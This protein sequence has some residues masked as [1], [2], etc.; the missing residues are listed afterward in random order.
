MK[1]YAKQNYD[2]FAPDAWAHRCGG[3]VARHPGIWTRLGNVETRVFADALQDI[4]VERPIYVSGLARAGTTIL[5]EALA[6]HRNIATHRYRDYPFVFTP[7]W[8]N[9]FLGR[10]PRGEAQAIERSHRDGI[11]VTPESP[12]AFEEML[13]M[14]FFPDAHNPATSQ[15]LNGDISH[16]RFERFY[17]EHIRKL[18][19][20][21]HAKR[22]LAKGNYNLTRLEYLLK[23]FPT[24]RFVIAVR[25]PVAHIASLMKQ[26]ALFCAAEKAHPRALAYMR[27]VGH[28]EFGL[29][30]RPV[31]A[32]D[33]E[34]I[35]AVE[36]CWQG[37]REVEGWARY[38]THLYGYV[39][40]RLA[41]SARLREAVGVIR[42]E[43]LC[44][45]PEKTLAELF[46]HCGLQN[47][48]PLIA[49]AAPTI[50][51]PTYYAPSF[52]AEDMAT[53]ARFT[54]PTRERLG[55]G[56]SADSA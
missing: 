5:L 12:E 36:H 19:F 47:A 6:R 13:W 56:T 7:L 14:A 15:G 39:A 41:A 31:N 22:Y 29:D 18:L 48:Q 50:R 43:D 25:E 40:D 10:L 20:L 52:D 17:N 24:A 34:A 49:H 35:A 53:I 51:A 4:R 27:R 33:D 54:G 42:Y 26:H 3:W 55:Y 37:G 8:W 46:D 16:A 1:P 9:G 28:F 44:R 32:G 23:L 30:R 38:W 21:R 11:R 2:D 45:E